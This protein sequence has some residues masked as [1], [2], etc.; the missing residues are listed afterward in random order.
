MRFFIL[1]A[2]AMALLLSPLAFAKGGQPDDP[3]GMLGQMNGS[4]EANEVGTGQEHAET[5]AGQETGRGNTVQQEQQTRNEGQGLAIMQQ[6]GNGNP[7]AMA[8]NQSIREAKAKYAGEM[9]GMPEQKAQV[10][11]NQNKVRV[12]VHALLG[13]ENITGIGKNVS[14]IAREF[15]NSVQA[16]VRSEER[17]R[18]RSGIERFLFGG[19]ENAAGELEQQ[20]TQNQERVMQM[21]LLVLQC[22]GCDAEVQ[23]M[24]QGQLQ[25]M[26][27]EQARLMQLAQEEKQEKGIFGWLWK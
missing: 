21:Q 6:A 15:D 13:A 16:T 11:Q 22:S 1:A 17:I 5:Q 10:Y 4:E 3:P 23:T 18:E 8:L 26:E 9:T 19:D 25:N 14:A 20:A 12:A 7:Q 27:Q 24:L 2:L